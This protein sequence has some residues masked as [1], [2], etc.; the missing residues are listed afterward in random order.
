MRYS[1]LQ[2]FVSLI[3][4]G[5]LGIAFGIIPLPDWM[6]D[7]STNRISLKNQSASYDAAQNHILESVEYGYSD[8]DILDEI[9]K[10]R[11][12]SGAGPL[13]FS[14]DL[15]RS[16]RQKTED[17]ITHTYFSHERDGRV[18]EN[19]IEDEHYEYIVIGENL[20]RGEFKS[21]PK[22]VR[23]WLSSPAHKKNIVDPRFQ[24]TGIALI[25]GTYNGTTVLYVTQHFGT[26]KSVCLNISSKH[27]SELSILQQTLKER[28]DE[29]IS[30]KQT[31][32]DIGEAGTERTKLLNL[33]Q[34][35]VSDLNA[36][37][38]T[39][40]QKIEGEDTLIQ[41]YNECIHSYQ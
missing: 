29:V 7:Y 23:A 1:F 36:I 41:A 18:F 25:P 33:Y 34:K 32:S 11:V 16:A 21:V 15:E 9:N 5:I 30:I 40:F 17:M 20:A 27:S 3:I 19:F 38:K 35:K 14:I 4:L 12:K 10:E 31:L 37:Q 2:L 13:V 24:E 22:L 6:T 39:L 26:Q 8:M 28:G